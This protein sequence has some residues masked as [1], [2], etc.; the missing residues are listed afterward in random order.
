MKDF[1]L[2]IGE[3][4]F[5]VDTKHSNGLVD[6]GTVYNQQILNSE[7]TNYIFVFEIPEKYIKSDLL[8]IYN[9]QG[10][11]TK[12]N[13]NPQNYVSNKVTQTSTVKELMNFK[14]TLGNIYFSFGV[15]KTSL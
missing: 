3:A 9:D 6:I 12:I 5:H 7:Y 15:F 4:V 10:I 11:K 14:D 13:L 1:S 8:F 2:E